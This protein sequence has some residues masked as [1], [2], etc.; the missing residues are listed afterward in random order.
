[1]HRI[2]ASQSLKLISVEYE[3]FGR[4]QGLFNLYAMQS[5][6]KECL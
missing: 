2:M 1:M 6:F 3:V 4:V 5:K